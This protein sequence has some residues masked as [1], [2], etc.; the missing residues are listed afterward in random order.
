M[1]TEAKNNLWW[2]CPRSQWG[3]KCY[4]SPD[5]AGWE[6]RGCR[7]MMQ[8]ETT[9]QG[10]T[11]GLCRVSVY[12]LHALS[13]ELLGYIWKRHFSQ[14]R[15]IF[16]EENVMRKDLI[17][18]P[19]GCNWVDEYDLRSYDLSLNRVYAVYD[20]C[21]FF[22]RGDIFQFNRWVCLQWNLSILPGGGEDSQ[23]L[24]T[25]WQLVGSCQQPKLSWLA[26]E[27]WGGCNCIH[28]DVHMIVEGQ[29]LKVR[30]GQYMRVHSTCQNIF[31]ALMTQ[32]VDY[33]M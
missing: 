12:G 6:M 3:E 7:V 2:N 11:L 9:S 25:G 26:A 24:R 23:W 28:R 19:L 22:S 13:I 21:D 27:N 20:F 5:G 18:L 17:H 4:T 8:Q 16:S 30:K 31:Q 1:K 33:L 29:G 14:N 15:K 10:Q 32:Y